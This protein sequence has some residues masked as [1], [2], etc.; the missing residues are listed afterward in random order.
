VGSIQGPKESRREI[1]LGKPANSDRK[2]SE[3]D[4]AI[5]DLSKGRNLKGIL[6]GCSEIPV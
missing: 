1:E 4:N 2:K 5:R 6:G 3:S